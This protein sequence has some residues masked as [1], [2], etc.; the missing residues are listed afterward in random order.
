MFGIWYGKGPG[1]DRCGDV[2]KHA[3]AA[4]TSPNG[5]VLALA[6]DD[7]GCQVLD[8][9]ASERPRLH[10]R[11]DAGAQSGDACRTSRPRPAGLRDV[12][13]LRLLGRLQGDHRDGRDLGRRSTS[14]PTR[15]KIVMPDRFRD[16]AGRP[17]HPLAR[18]RR[19]SRSGGCTDSRCYAALAFA[20][21]N[22]LDR[23][24]SI[25]RTRAARHHG[26]RQGL[27]R[28]PPGAGAISASPSRGAAQARAAP[29]QGRHD[30]AAGA[31]R[32]ARS[33]PKACEE[34][35]VVEEKREIIENQLKQELLQLARRRPP[36]RGRQ[37]GRDTAQ[38]CLPC[39]GEL[40][41]TIGRGSSL[42]E[43]LLQARPSQPE[44][45][46]AAPRQGST[47]FDRPAGRP[48]QARAKLH[49][50]AV[51]LLG[52]PAQHLDQGARRQP[53]HGRH[54]LPLHGA[55]D[56]PP[57]R[58]PSP[59]WA[60]KACRGSAQAP[61]T[62]RRAR[63]RRTSATAP[64]SIPASWRSARRSPPASTSPTRSSTTTRSR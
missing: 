56:G 11:A 33:S 41:P 19:W 29:L 43:R 55:V 18:S 59:T 23:I 48:M 9:A 20:R 8:P 38:R 2:F 47:A 25:R 10:R 39:D 40:T 17:Q 1:V 35:L 34:I 36:A 32:R 62:E 13:L 30:L 53:R 3:N 26:D 44:S 46:R 4:G 7:H 52:L 42:A 64:T 16:A 12:A 51:F 28:H 5:G 21:A 57:H 49:A 37:D 27:S 54:R 60:A 45:L 58:R 31:G 61:F 63:V 22:Q 14:I 50:H 15:I 24:V 6:G